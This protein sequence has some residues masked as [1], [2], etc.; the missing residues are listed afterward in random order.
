MNKF[1]TPYLHTV[2][3]E[4]SFLADLK[5]T[6]WNHWRHLRPTIPAEERA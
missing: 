5:E 4:I 6:S 1:K 3:L 2:Y